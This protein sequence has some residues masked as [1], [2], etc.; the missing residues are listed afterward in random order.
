MAPFDLW[1]EFQAFRGLAQSFESRADLGG[2]LPSANHSGALV[3]GLPDKWTGA[4]LGLS[5]PLR[6]HGSLSGYQDGV[7]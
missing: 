5:P 2:H 1:A 7:G 4:A 6:R 3:R